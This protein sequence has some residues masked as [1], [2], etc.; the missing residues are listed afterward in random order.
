MSTVRQDCT[1]YLS[2]TEILIISDDPCVRSS[3]LDSIHGQK[4]AA[5]IVTEADQLQQTLLSA[6]PDLIF[7]D[8]S[9]QVFDAIAICKQLQTSEFGH[10]AA[11]ILIFASDDLAHRA[12]GYTAGAADFLIKPLLPKEVIAKLTTHIRQPAPREARSIN[13]LSAERLAATENSRQ[14]SSCDAC[15]QLPLQ[16]RYFQEIFHNLSDRICL[17]K[18]S[19]DGRFHYL[20]TN[21]A[22]ELNAGVAEDSLLGQYLDDLQQ[23]AK[24]PAFDETTIAKLHRCLDTG[25]I[26]D[27]EVT[28]DTKT[29]Q[30]VHHSTLTPLFNDYGRIDRILCVSRDITDSKNASRLNDFLK[31]ALD[32][33]NDAVFLI[34]P[35]GG[36]RF[37]YV[38]EQA[39]RSLGYSRD[40]LLKMSVLDID[41]VLDLEAARK[42]DEQLRNQAYT[43]FETFHRRKDGAVFAV[44]IS[45]TAIEYEGQTL[46]LAIVR[47]ISERKRIEQE[48]AAREQEFRNLAESTPDGIIRYDLNGRIRY[49]NAGLLGYLG[50]NA[51]DVIGKRPS[52]VWPDGRYA[53]IEHANAQA[54]AA[55]ESSTV[56]FSEADAVGA[57]HFNQI[58]IVPE[59]D[60]GGQI[61]GSLAVGRDVTAIRI[62]ERQLSHFIENLPGMAYSFRLSPD[63]HGSMP[64]A[65]PSI[66]EYY[67]L[68]PEDVKDDITPAHKHMHPDDLRIIEVAITESARTMA[69]FRAEYRIC[70]PN[71]PERWLEA[72]SLPERQADG[73]ILW[74]GIVLDITERKRAEIALTASE[75]MLSEAQAIA[76]LGSWDWDVVK[77]RVEWSD[78]AYDIYTPDARPSA[79][80]YEEFKQSVHP[81]DLERVDTAV[82]SAFEHDTPFDIEHRVVSLSKGV[83]TV[84]AQ[85]KVFRDQNGNPIRM[86][87]TVQDITERKQIELD[88]KLLTD[89]LE[90]SPDFVGTVDLQGK[91]GYHNPAARR[92]VGLPTDADVSKMRIADMHP[93]WVTKLIM[94]TALPIVMKRGVWR[95]ETAL[96]HRDGREIPVQQTIM[97]HSDTNGKPMG[98]STIMQDITEGKR[99]EEERQSHLHFFESMD[100]VNRALQ[101]SNDLETVLN[102]LLEEMLDL[103]DCDRAYLI[104]PCDP[105]ADSWSVP[106]ERTRPEY[107]GVLALNLNMPMDEGMAETF[108]L[109]LNAEGPTTYGPGNKHPLPEECSEQF[110]FKSF[111]SMILQPMGDKPWAFGIHQ[112]SRTRVWSSYEQKL[113]QEIGRRLADALTGLLAYRSLQTSER[114]FRTLAENLPD[115]IVRYNREGVTVYVNP[116]LERTLGDIADSMIGTIPRNYHPDGSYEDYAQLLDAVLASGK[117]GE[118]EKILPGPN[119]SANIHQIRIVPERGEN[120]EVIGALSIG[121][122][123]TERKQAEEALHASEQKFRSLAENMPDIL[124][125][126][127]RE[128]RR[129]YVNPALI[130]NYAVRAEQMI[131]LMQQE[132]NPFNMPETYRRALEHT[133][134]TGERSELEL[135]IPTSSGDIRDNLVFIAA[136]WA[137]D[138]QISGAITI[139]H[140]ITE[141]KRMEAELVSQAE[142]QQTLLNAMYDVG[143]QLM[144]IEN[145]KIIHIGNRKNLLKLG[146]TEDE[147]DGQLSLMDIVHPDERA[148]V[149]D[150]HR[151]RLAGETV[152]TTYELGLVT[153][154]GQRREYETSVAVVPGTDPERVVSIGR[155]ITEQVRL[156]EALAA[157][158]REF[159]TL[160]ENSPDSI[161]RYDSH[162]RRTYVNRAYEIATNS[163][164]EDIIGKTP[165]EDWRLA[166]PNADEYTATLRRVMA[167]RKVERLEVQMLDGGGSPHYFSMQFVPEYDEQGQVNGVLSFAPDITELK[168]YQRE[169]ETSRSQLRALAIRGEKMR[170]DERKRIA[171]E[172]H[173]D[174]GQRLTA[175]KLDLARM[176]L[177]FC[178][179]NPQLQQQIEEMERDLGSTIQIVRDV[180][181]QLRPS[182]LEM[183]IVS[184]LEWLILEFRR[185]SN[186]QCRLRIPKHKIILNDSQATVMFRIVQESLTNIMRHAKASEVEIILASDI[187]HHRLEIH[188]D[189]VGFDAYIVNKSNSFGLIGIEERALSLGGTLCIDTA[190]NQGVRLSIRIP[191]SHRDQEARCSEF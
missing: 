2:P 46:S 172:L 89:I 160:A 102:N 145:G 112:C 50:V 16:R 164:R 142:F 47:D 104:H 100:R 152:P 170:E 20:E 155:E 149:M 117:A 153:R 34:D 76:K 25:C 185:H 62:A 188:D 87:G 127:D 49:L 33:A 11:I 42:V 39:C 31:F 147:L 94:E 173:D 168:E 105:D 67:G 5:N 23:P 83:R 191:I 174:L 84:H 110:C 45:T 123:I 61:V 129:T 64:F 167:T 134:A 166:A 24:A 60:A 44:E 151:R 63:G 140:D 157:H 3:L 158:E 35:A 75:R 81:D 58:N 98:T 57:L 96:L 133:L 66:K 184:A 113:F 18:V 15:Q 10:D 143:M 148:R 126:Y 99:M 109:L 38:N 187:H 86:V 178:S 183:G 79:P 72:R 176:Q 41:P 179:D 107:P 37:R 95:G 71:L 156:R 26:I 92:M 144:V 40:E 9:T 27:E 162:C 137:T 73:G 171:R 36:H 88:R 138:G 180:A 132:S 69:P 181:T 177:R 78:M 93:E 54:V 65:S 111:M 28:L 175:L 22:F 116:A 130:R 68:L 115:N 120:G 182:A 122:D 131:G 82:R 30:R 90:E 13:E 103:F 21:R 159:R 163:R 14:E 146:L 1:D 19:E 169:L 53:D 70:L 135:R 121:R 80:G 97:L 141:R 6:K 91:L 108:R 101:G 43:R 48:M 125:S 77:N 32:Q 186:I 29:G 56:E 150:Y 8:F 136:E 139:G 165:L 128:G 17:L 59:R 4:I 118:L 106:I 124:I 52:E 114:E 189:G 74:N 85:A 190:P 55:G 119:G 7:V 161:I 51:E 154:D 12:Q